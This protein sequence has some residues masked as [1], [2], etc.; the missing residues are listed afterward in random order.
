MYSAEVPTFLIPSRYVALIIPPE[1][2]IV[3]IFVNFVISLKCYIYSFLLKPQADKKLVTEWLR[4]PI[5]NL[6][7]LVSA[8]LNLYE[9]LS[10]AGNVLNENLIPCLRK[11]VN[12]ESNEV[13]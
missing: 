3:H 5:T 10:T 12:I 9:E 8:H 4:Y 6:E 2:V 11:V 13:I 7:I 1:Y